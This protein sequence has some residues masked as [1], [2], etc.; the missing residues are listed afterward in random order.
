MESRQRRVGWAFVS[1]PLHAP[2]VMDSRVIEVLDVISASYQQPLTCGILARGVNLS[3]SQLHS[4]F[5]LHTNTTPHAALTAKR[6]EKAAELLC[7][8]RLLVKEVASKVGIHND[9]HF[10]RDFEAAFGR[11]PTAFRVN[12]ASYSYSSGEKAHN[13]TDG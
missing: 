6:M 5:R 10:V 12:N 7:T 4:L 13:R 2:S 3:L 11:S 8:T 1:R 9:S